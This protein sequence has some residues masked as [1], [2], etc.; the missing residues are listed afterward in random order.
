MPF[1]STVATVSSR[2]FVNHLLHAPKPPFGDVDVPVRRVE[3]LRFLVGVP[4]I[5]EALRVAQVFEGVPQYREFGAAKLKANE[6][7]RSLPR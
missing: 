3:H 4:L 5:E 7:M 2:A 1:A 6:D